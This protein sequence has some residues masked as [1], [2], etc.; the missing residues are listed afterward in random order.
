MKLLKKLGYGFGILIIFIA[1]S[2]VSFATNINQLSSNEQVAFNQVKRQLA[3]QGTL[4]GDF[5]QIRSISLLKN[6][7]IS[8]GIFKL[9]RKDGLT[10]N[11]L[12]PY[13]SSLTVTDDTIIQIIKGRPPTILKKSD[14]PIVFAFTHIFLSLFQG[15]IALVQTYFDIS[16]QGDSNKWQ[17]ELTPISSPLNKAIKTITVKGGRYVSF[18]EVDQ[19]QGD[20]MEIYFSNIKEVK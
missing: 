9:S 20:K 2:N 16:F 3:K 7:L 18:I 13:A 11:Q 12:K 14:Q 5:R 8:T 17:A 10:W 15:D 1:L 6:P 19:S 4:T